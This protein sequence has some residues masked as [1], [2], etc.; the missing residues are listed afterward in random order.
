MS[1]WRAVFGKGAIETNKRKREKRK[2]R[3]EAERT[4]MAVV[5]NCFAHL[6]SIA[7][8]PRPVGSCV[9]VLLARYDFA[10]T[11]DILPPNTPS[12]QALEVM[13]CYAEEAPDRF[14]T[15]A[16]AHKLAL[17]DVV[18]WWRFEL[19][20][21]ARALRTSADRARD[22]LGIELRSFY[23]TSPPAADRWVHRARYEVCFS[24]SFF[25]C[26]VP[27]P[28]VLPRS[29]T[30]ERPSIRHRRDPLQKTQ[31]KRGDKA[32]QA[33]A[34]ALKFK[35]VDEKAFDKLARNVERLA[36]GSVATTEFVAR[37]LFDPRRPAVRNERY[38]PRRHRHDHHTHERRWARAEGGGA[39]APLAEVAELASP[40]AGED[41]YGHEVVDVANGAAAAAFLAAGH[42][43]IDV[44]AM[45]GLRVD[46]HPGSTA[47]GTDGLHFCMPG[48]LDYALDIVLA[49][50]GSAFDRGGAEIDGGFG[51]LE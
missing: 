5:Y 16:A 17:A 41:E 44:A 47:G 13:N 1:V 32:K 26:P 8:F 20:A 46:A 4:R 31:A 39:A 23:R 34:P 19:A 37:V 51:G 45:L 2:K 15:P 48:P 43:V 3:H 12:T 25:P 21:M 18:A 22:E 28:L 10:I 27:G 35:A 50:V 42:G 33:L 14:P 24:A 29:P 9:S 49:R 6:E 36:A 38:T 7:R 30:R 11:R 40:P